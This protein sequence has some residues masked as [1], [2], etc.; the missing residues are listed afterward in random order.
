M[1]SR[2]AALFVSVG[3]DLKVRYRS[4]S[5]FLCN[6]RSF[7]MARIVFDSVYSRIGKISF[8]KSRLTMSKG[9]NVW[10]SLRNTAFSKVSENTPAQRPSFLLIILAVSTL[11]S[12]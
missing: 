7:S 6:E 5:Q 3:E 9:Q 4:K 8:V 2:T 1:N 12:Q 10:K 11:L